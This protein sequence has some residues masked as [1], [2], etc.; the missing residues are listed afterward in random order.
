MTRWNHADLRVT[1]V[2]QKISVQ[3]I[4]MSRRQPRQLSPRAAGDVDRS[5]KG[6]VT[7]ESFNAII[8]AAAAQPR[9]AWEAWRRR[10][11]LAAEIDPN[12]IIFPRNH[13]AIDLIYTEHGRSLLIV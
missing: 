10:I 9:C 12:H 3:D 1:K 7:A 11:G 8:I 13:P 2:T 4:E 6:S 5:D